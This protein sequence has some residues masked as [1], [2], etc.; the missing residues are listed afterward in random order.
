M[1]DKYNEFLI[2]EA[3]RTNSSCFR[4]LWKRKSSATSSILRSDT[5]SQLS[6]VSNFSIIT[7]SNSDN[8]GV[9]GTRDAI[10]KF[11]IYFRHLEVLLVVCVI[12]LD[13]S[14]RWGVHH[15][16]LLETLDSLVLGNHSTTVSA[17]DSVCVTLVFLVSSVVPSLWWHIYLIYLYIIL[18]IYYCDCLSISNRLNLSI[19]IIKLTCIIVRTICNLRIIFDE[20]T[21]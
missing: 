1:N 13:I 7:A 11:D 4:E 21:L 5:L 10:A 3:L 18:S 17:S 20:K 9:N 16:S 15:V 19:N 12:F 8:S 6:G 14:L 2:E